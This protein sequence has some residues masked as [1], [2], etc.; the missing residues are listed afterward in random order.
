MTHFNVDHPFKWWG[1]GLSAIHS[2]RR[3]FSLL[4]II[5]CRCATPR[6]WGAE[7]WCHGSLPDTWGEPVPCGMTTRKGSLLPPTDLSAA[8]GEMEVHHA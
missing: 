6:F 2:T 8:S 5:L 3:F 7:R 4:N 1:S